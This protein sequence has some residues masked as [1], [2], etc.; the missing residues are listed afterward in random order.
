MADEG[1]QKY[2]SAEL[3]KWLI[4]KAEKAR[5]PVTARKIISANDQRENG[6]ASDRERGEIMVGTVG[7]K[8]KED[9]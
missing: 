3:S 9:R 7:L 6:R 1:K 8:K 2:S 5:N 4:E